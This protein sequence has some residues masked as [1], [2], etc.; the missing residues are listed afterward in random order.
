MTVTAPATDHIP[1]LTI[2]DADARQFLAAVDRVKHALPGPTQRVTRWHL[3]T[4][5]VHRGPTGGYVTATDGYRMARWVFHVA[6]D[7]PPFDGPVSAEDI[8]AYR[9]AR[10]GALSLPLA[11]GVSYPDVWRAAREAMQGSVRLGR[12]VG[13]AP[14][15]RAVSAFEC[16]GL[17]SI[18]IGCRGAD[19]HI[20]AEDAEANLKI[21]AHVANAIEGEAEA[22]C[23]INP[24]YLAD[25]LR[26]IERGKLSGSDVVA[27]LSLWALKLT[28][29]NG[30]DLMAEELIMTRRE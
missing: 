5:H 25:A 27:D 12:I 18:R 17:D 15:L 10:N 21:R 16:A 14:L 6:D 3:Y 1:R 26:A 8:D 20:A 22:A 11:D 29:T 28:V 19:V 2:A 24:A 23:S 9:K 4:Y 7:G 13:I 30:A